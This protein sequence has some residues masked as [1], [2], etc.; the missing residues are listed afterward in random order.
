MASFA[1]TR[2][3]P[4]KSVV[5]IRSTE[6]ELPQ[7]ALPVLVPAAAHTPGTP[8]EGFNAWQTRCTRTLAKLARLGPGEIG[9]CL[10]A[11]GERRRQDFGSRRGR[12]PY[13]SARGQRFCLGSG[14]SPVR[15]KLRAVP[16][17]SPRLKN[18]VSELIC[19]LGPAAQKQ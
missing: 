18:N 15:D 6:S 3:A 19:R 8:S 4:C 16:T 2:T 9:G 5:R 10:F 11:H 13:D 17:R 1:Q 12:N 14:A 7:V